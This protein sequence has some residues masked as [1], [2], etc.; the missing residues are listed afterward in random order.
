MRHHSHFAAEEGD[1]DSSDVRV[2]QCDDPAVRVARIIEALYQIGDCAF[3]RS[4]GADDGDGFA[5]FDFETDIS[6]N[7]VVWSGGVRESDVLK[8]YFTLD[9]KFPVA[10]GLFGLC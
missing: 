8:R 5:R 10:D 6:K 7:C 2:V 1:I 9:R 4:G 3:P